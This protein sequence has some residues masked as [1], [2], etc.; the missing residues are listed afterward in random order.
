MTHGMYA[1]NYQ[2]PVCKL[3]ADR[4]LDDNDLASQPTLSRF[5][6]AITMESLKRLRKVFLDQFLSAAAVG[7]GQSAS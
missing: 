2:D 6:N 4:S 5:E 7:R 1:L 3:V